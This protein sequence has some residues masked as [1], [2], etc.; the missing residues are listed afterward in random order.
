[1][2]QG[3]PEDRRLVNARG[4]E[5]RVLAW[6][7]RSAAS[8]PCAAGSSTRSTVNPAGSGV[9]D[10]VPDSLAPGC[11]PS[12]SGDQVR[13]ESNSIPALNARAA[14]GLT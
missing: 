11:Y 5:E 10:P 6:T 1:V 7:G 3:A 4:E 9:I 14:A 8:A 2:R 13:Q 12:R